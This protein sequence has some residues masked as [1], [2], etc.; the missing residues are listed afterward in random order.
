[1][2]EEFIAALEQIEREKGVGKEI[3]FEA[4]ESALLN[5]Y[6]KN[7]GTSH[8]VRV[9][10]DKENGD[11]KVLAGRTVV[12]KEEEDI[13][14][15]EISLKEAREVFHASY[16]E[17]DVIESEITP[18]N[19]GRI[20]AQAARQMVIQKI[21]EAERDII[22]E[23]F[24]NRESEII[25]G[26]IIR[27]GKGNVYI[28]L[29]IIG[30]RDITISAEA[31][32]PSSEQI[33]FEEYTAGNRIKVYILEV[34]KNNNVPQI[35][36]SRSH[37]GLVK[38]LF[39]SEVPEIFDGVVQIRSISREAGSRTKMAVHSLDENVDPIGACVGSKGQRVKNIV[40]ELQGEK[41]DIIKYSEDP[42]EYISAALS[43]SKVL[44]VNVCEEEKSA[45]VIVP[46]D[47]LSLA[48]G[49]EGQNARLAAK[50]TNWKIDIKS[51]SQLAETETEILYAEETEEFSD[52]EE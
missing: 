25:T 52:P 11:V 29:T 50:L 37:P 34:K 1:M 22:Y 3:L 27:V 47:K 46:D 31:I 48:I 44:S 32:L 12:D 24:L 40:D 33:S 20:A 8:N 23:E 28:N 42:V 9:E 43:P 2:N 38:R 35:L 6:K 15:G 49:K 13:L 14:D 5:A 51:V 18:R 41:I 36:V 39:E 45:S 16:Q 26:E 4:L 10:M 30:S 21:K 19:F 7:F 17:G